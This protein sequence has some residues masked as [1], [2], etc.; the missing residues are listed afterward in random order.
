M[1]TGLLGEEGHEFNMDLNPANTRH[2]PNVVSML[3][4]RLRRWPNIGT[5]LGECL[6]FAG[7][8]TQ[9]VVSLDVT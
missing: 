6:V 7:N 5:A 1:N 8:N 3:A 2:S 4:H 9:K